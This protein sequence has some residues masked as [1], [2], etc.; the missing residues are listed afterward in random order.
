MGIDCCIN[1]WQKDQ[2]KEGMDRIDQK[3]KERETIAD[4]AKFYKWCLPYTIRL[5]LW[6]NIFSFPTTCLQQE[7]L[8]GSSLRPRSKFTSLRESLKLSWC[9]K[10][11]L[12]QYY[13]RSEDCR[14]DEMYPSAQLPTSCP[15][16]SKVLAFVRHLLCSSELLLMQLALSHLCFLK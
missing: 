7:V 8:K 13:I 2:G 4:H 3:E 14:K 11:P 10:L 15:E 1:Q 6:V 12:S 16:N 9:T 5:T